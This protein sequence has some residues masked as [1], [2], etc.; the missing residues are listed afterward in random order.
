M[1]I[2]WKWH[3]VRE[4]WLPLLLGGVGLVIAL[5]LMGWR[6]AGL[7]PNLS[8]P[9]IATY[10]S[11]DSMSD[12]L[13]NTV[14]GPYKVS[15]YVVTRI[16]NN[17]FGLR[18][19]GALVGVIAIA[20]FYLMAQK[21]LTARNAIIATLLFATSSIFLHTTRLA[22]PNVMLLAL[23][24][25][26]AVGSI[27]RYEKRNGIGWILA[28]IVIALSL[29]TPGL[30]LFIMFGALW[31]LRRVKT[32]FSSLR[33]D[34][35]IICAVI[36]SVLS[37]PLIIG[38]IR[39][40]NVFRQ[41]A[42]VPESLPTL[43]EFS[44]RWLL[45]PSSLIAVSPKEPVYWLGRQPV[46]DAFAIAM[47]LFGLITVGRQYRLDRLILFLGVFI[48]SSLWI[49]FSG[50]HQA[51]ILIVPFMY[52]VIGLGMQEFSERWLSVFPRNP[53]ARYTG[54]GVFIVAVAL[55][56]NFQTQRYFV[57]WGNSPETAPAFSH[58]LSD[59]SK[60]EDSFWYNYLVD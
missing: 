42:G 33:P 22:T 53:I 44:I 32:S 8:E 57:A 15:V 51:I 24:A 47:F 38:L 20:L 25:L 36:F 9:E 31:Q 28:S 41:L 13:D 26:V 54:L 35:L 52:L 60:P 30:F 27:I 49:A 3:A 5:G 50:N 7:T 19:I 11:A 18:L 34:I 17:A 1:K 37:V 46:L 55:T 40:P 29:Y 45:I 14:D 48:L 39:D 16:F 10:N 2:K 4:L 59:H 23:L 43:R 58:K 21:I 6:L 56:I 12:I